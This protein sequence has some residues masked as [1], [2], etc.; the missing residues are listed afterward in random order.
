MLGILGG[1]G[2]LL[3]G[4]AAGG[5][6]T[7]LLGLINGI[8]GTVGGIGN[9]ISQFQNNKTRKKLTDRLVQEY[10]ERRAANRAPLGPDVPQAPQRSASSLYGLTDLLNQSKQG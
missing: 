4:G 10:D 7:G 1:L 9:L 6:L 3:G 8:G 5:G 2:G